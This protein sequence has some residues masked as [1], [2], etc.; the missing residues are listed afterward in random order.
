MAD[1]LTVEVVSPERVLWHGSASAVSAPTV[2][3]EIG[4]LADHEPILSLLG[5]GTVR[6]RSEAEGQKDFD[7]EFGFI[8]FDHNAVTV[9]VRPEGARHIYGVGD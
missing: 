1:A 5:A 2:E 4:L 9:V 7:I 3:G 8:S 6:V